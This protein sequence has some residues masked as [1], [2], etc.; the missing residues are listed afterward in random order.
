MGRAY[1]E[2]RNPTTTT[3]GPTLPRHEN[4]LARQMSI[5]EPKPYEDELVLMDAPKHDNMDELAQ[6]RKSWRQAAA[7]WD[8]Q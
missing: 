3:V 6:D 2:P 5:R 7:T 4:F 1:L 8:M